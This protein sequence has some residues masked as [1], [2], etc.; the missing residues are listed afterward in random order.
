LSDRL[1][2]H[3]SFDSTRATAEAA[4]DDP[5]L[6]QGQI[7]AIISLLLGRSLAI[8]NTYGL[9]SRTVLEL[10]DVMLSVRSRVIQEQ[11]DAATRARL[12]SWMPFALYRWRQPN[13]LAACADQF[14]RHDKKAK[15]Y[16]RLSAWAPINDDPAARDAIAHLLGRNDRGTYEPFPTG[17]AQ[18][19]PELAQQYETLLR[20]DAYFKNPAFDREARAPKIALD[21]YVLGLI[22][23]DDVALG[24]IADTQRCPRELAV[25][26]RD[27]LRERHT[28]GLDLNF[29]RGWAHDT[30]NAL[31]PDDEQRFLPE[32]VRQFVDT[33]Y[34]AVL[35]DSANVEFEYM[36]SVPRADGRDELKYVNA[37]GLG[38][39][40]DTRNPGASGRKDVAERIANRMG[41]LLA[42]A[43]V[44][45]N[46]PPQRLEPILTEYWELLADP[47]RARSWRQSI[48][49]L[50]EE[51][52][53]PAFD[54]PRF[55][56]AWSAHIA[57]LAQ[58]LPR[59]VS[60][61]GE[62]LAVNVR[63]GQQTYVQTQQLGEI[64]RADL[65]N[66]LAA[67]E[68]LDDLSHAASGVDA[69]AR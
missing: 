65:D 30:V 47:D 48:V 20:L 68:H 55:Q 16:F 53:R 42:A 38:I 52:G 66:A 21:A 25:K 17:L 2:F 64:E 4:R 10:A 1:V 27:T 60:V 51:L 45:P 12:S 32:L 46:I 31:S 41:G 57:Q 40:R 11:P 69:D 24:V 8:N 56:D 5:N 59:I 61:N 58:M 50:H 3:E 13:Y 6:V 18:S 29:V 36:S 63:Q 54:A 23:L 62:E 43:S 14:R 7:E 15:N 67:G 35:A 28:Q 39:I 44:L 33:V 37:L 26:V 34:N 19:Y 49:L 9:D 22:E